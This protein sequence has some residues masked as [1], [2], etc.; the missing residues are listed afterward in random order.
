MITNMDFVAIISELNRG[1]ACGYLDVPVWRYI[2]VTI[3]TVRSEKQQYSI[4][5][6]T[7][8]VESVRYQPVFNGTSIRVWHR[9]RYSARIGDG[10]P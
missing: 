6:K 10:H 3:S 5:R 1:Y 9:Q 2:T 4:D 7:A 8:S